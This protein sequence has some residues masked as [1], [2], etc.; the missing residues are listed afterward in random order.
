[1]KPAKMAVGAG[2]EFF[3]CAVLDDAALV[4]HQNAVHIA[5]RGE[6]VRHD[7]GRPI[8][9]ERVEVGQQPR[10]GFH[11]ERARR[12]VEHD[13]A[14]VAEKNSSQCDALALATRKF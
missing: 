7:E 9:A 2:E 11:V 3:P 6:P 10:L 4:K 1:M 14:G 12:F 13:D 5:Q 8:T